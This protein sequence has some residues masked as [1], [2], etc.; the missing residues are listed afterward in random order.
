MT[1]N[2]AAAPMGGKRLTRR[3]IPGEAPVG[4]LQTRY[5][6][7]HSKEALM[8]EPHSL[9]RPAWIKI[10]IAILVVALL[11]AL[12][13]LAPLGAWISA[14][15]AW[16]AEAGPLGWIAFILV[17]AIAVFA[18]VPGS[19]LTLA[20]G[21]AYGLWG[22][23]LVV[24]GASLGAMAS[25]IAGRVFFRR[26]VQ[27]LIENRPRLKAVDAAIAEE[28]WRVAILLRLSPAVPFSL[29]NWALGGT[30][31]SLPAFVIA[32]VLG[33]IPGTALYVWIGSLGAAASGAAGPWRTALLA[34]GLIAS[35]AIVWLT[36]RAAARR[37]A[38]RDI[39]SD[40]T[41]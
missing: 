15:R 1:R 32:T 4:T 35:F 30:G 9:K 25:F 7:L 28:G 8:T 40:E 22:I 19:I 18:L 11:A 27:R 34:A 37:L 36:T 2:M 6:R 26:S 5:I 12:W 20:A 10:I 21:V 29:Q 41:A 23:P 13:A 16:A 38:A 24:A 31:L 39:K 17:Y 14:F 33:I 3:S